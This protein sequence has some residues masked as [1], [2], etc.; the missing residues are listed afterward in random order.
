MPRLDFFIQLKTQS[1][2]AIYS[3]KAVFYSVSGFDKMAE[4]QNEE[5][6][7]LKYLIKFLGIY[8]KYEVLWDT[9]SFY[10]LGS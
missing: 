3:C 5:K 9:G 1:L 2:V 10:F 7:V 6:W 8:R 4:L